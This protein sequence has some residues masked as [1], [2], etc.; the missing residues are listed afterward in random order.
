MT[1]T[2]IVLAIDHGWKLG[3]HGSWCRQGT[4]ELALRVPFAIHDPDADE[5]RRLRPVSLTGMYPTWAEL[6]GSDPD[7]RH[8]NFKES[9]L[10]MF[11]HP[12]RPAPPEIIKQLRIS[13]FRSGHSWSFPVDA[14]FGA[15]PMI[16]PIRECFSKLFLGL[17][18]NVTMTILEKKLHFL[19]VSSGL[20]V[21]AK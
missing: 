20:G 15:Q 14:S 1:D 13:D 10:P 18:D 17:A 7:S 16:Q 9:V 12:N 19:I 5:T 11:W 21:R 2:V 8:E 6:G 4:F 3:E